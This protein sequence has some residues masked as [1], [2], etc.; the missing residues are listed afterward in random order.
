[1]FGRTLTQLGSAGRNHWAE[2]HVSVMIGSKIK[3][4]VVG[5]IQMNSNLGEYTA[6]HDGGLGQRG[7]NLSGDV[8]TSDLLASFGKTLCHAVGMPQA[9]YDQQISKGKPS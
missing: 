8:P 9:V 5:G 2:H 6:G 4:G 1:M 3:G 7:H